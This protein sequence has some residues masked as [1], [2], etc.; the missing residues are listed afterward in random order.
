MREQKAERRVEERKGGFPHGPALACFGFCLRPRSDLDYDGACAVIVKLKFQFECQPLKHI[1][2]FGRSCCHYCHTGRARCAHSRR[3]YD[4]ISS[5]RADKLANGITNDG[6]D[7][8]LYVITN[9]RFRWDRH[10]ATDNHD[11]RAAW[12]CRNRSVESS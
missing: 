1:Q 9:A 4:P 10:D 2:P 5:R 12:D 3:A 6:H 8:E 7:L 11:G